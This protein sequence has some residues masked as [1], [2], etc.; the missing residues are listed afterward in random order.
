MLTGYVYFS[1]ETCD[2]DE[3]DIAYAAN[4]SDDCTIRKHGMHY[5]CKTSDPPFKDCH[6][7][8]KG[9]CADNTCAAEEITLKTDD[10]GDSILG[11]FCEFL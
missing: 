2:D 11:C 7:V 5:C 3:L 8:G 1:G 6:W 4:L 9:D 10:Q